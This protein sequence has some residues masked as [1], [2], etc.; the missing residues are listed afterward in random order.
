MTADAP[1]VDSIRAAY[2]RF[3]SGERILLT[4]HS[5]QAWPDVAREA[6]VA[7]FDDAAELCDDKWE[8]IFAVQHDVG[9]RILTRHGLGAGDAIAFGESTH[10][11]VYRLLSSFDLSTRPHVIT[12][13]G[14]FHSLHRQLRRLEEN[15][16]V[17]TWVPAWPRE[18]L[19]QR[20]LAAIDDADNPAL[21]AVSAVQFE[22]AF[23]VERLGEVL[24]AAIAAGA[25][26]L[27]DAYHAFNAVPLDWGPARDAVYVTA[28]GYKYAGFGN[29]LCWLRLGKDCD[30]RPAYTGWFADF[31]SL[32]KPRDGEPVRYGPAGQRFGGA[33]FDN[34][35][36]YRARAVL[37]HWDRFGLGVAELRA[38]STRQTSRL[39][40]SLGAGGLD[41]ASSE[42]DARRGAFVS[43][44]HKQA[45][46]LCDRIRQAGVWTDSRGELLRF[47]P[48]P[49]TTDGE[50]DRG[51]EVAIAAAGA[52]H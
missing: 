12:T 52:L 42:D 16:L 47:G 7:V 51:A 17:V 49:Y 15:G 3:L 38:I 45:K 33:T 2:R 28:G 11:L 26:P 21:V 34:S 5:H 31:A 23:V 25:I 43:V 8:R 1:N 22:D 44:R 18:G 14:E 27:V 6:Q 46:L 30:L 20:L 36:L 29:G 32:A 48:A 13:T 4:G 9:Q 10:Q 37:N 41:V 24:A 35:A 39:I 40:A 19:S 50:L